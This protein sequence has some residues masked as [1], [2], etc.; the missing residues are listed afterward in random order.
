[1]LN[2]TNQL[3]IMTPNQRIFTLIEWARPIKPLLLIYCLS[4]LFSCRS[5]LEVP[6]KPLNELTG[7]TDEFPTGSPKYNVSIIA[8]GKPLSDSRAIPGTTKEIELIAQLTEKSLKDYPQLNSTV[9]INKAIINLARGT[10]RVDFID[11]PGS[12]PLATLLK[13]AQAGDRFII[14]FDDVSVQTKQGVR[15]KVAKPNISLIAISVL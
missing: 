7:S 5:V 1:M 14:Q 10:Q 15:Q 3:A 12:R 13:Q 11:W 8:D 4:L 9:T 2:V 6:G